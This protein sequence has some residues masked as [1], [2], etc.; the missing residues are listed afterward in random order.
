MNFCA[1]IKKTSVVP[2][3]YYRLSY[4]KVYSLG[5]RLFRR[6]MNVLIYVQTKVGSECNIYIVNDQ[7]AIIS[8]KFFVTIER[9]ETATQPEFFRTFFNLQEQSV[10]KLT[11]FGKTPL[12]Y[13]GEPGRGFEYGVLQPITM[14]FN[15]APVPQG[16]KRGREVMQQ[17]PIGYD[18]DISEKVQRVRL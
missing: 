13:Q 7:G 10:L 17:R 15:E 16:E 9:V 5:D 3:S 8:A 2:G 1:F 12:T 18:D 14:V 6:E 11:T 4:L